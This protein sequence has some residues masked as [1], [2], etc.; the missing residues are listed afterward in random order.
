MN[1][2]VPVLCLGWLLSL[3]V[4]LSAQ[5]PATPPPDDAS[6]MQNPPPG[7]EPDMDQGGPGGPGEPGE[8]P[9]SAIDRWLD[10]LKER[11][12]NEYARLQKLRTENPDEFR[13][14]LRSRLREERFRHEFHDNPGFC[15]YVLG[16]PEKERA[17]ILKKLGHGGPG[18]GPLGMRPMSPEIQKLE[19]QTGEMAKAYRDAADETQKK[20]IREQLR[21][22]LEQLFDAREKERAEMIQRIEK[23]LDRLKQTLTQRQAHREE[24]IDKRLQEL[25]ADNPLA[26]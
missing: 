4:Q 14:V 25:T 23:D 12:T 24:I 2:I 3:P 18:R 10:M 8:P 5:E 22:K 17:D 15:K 19:V 9:A 7:A 13:R 26:W 20:D 6:A 11:N 1:R 21:T 16:L